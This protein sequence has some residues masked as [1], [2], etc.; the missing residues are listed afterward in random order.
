MLVGINVFCR[1]A[2]RRCLWGIRK[3]FA[4]LLCLA[5][6]A[7]LIANPC[8]FAAN[9]TPA[10][11]NIILGQPVMMDGS[12]CLKKYGAAFCACTPLTG[13]GE[14]CFYRRPP[15]G[16]YSLAQCEHSS[17]GEPRGSPLSHHRTSDVAYGGF[18]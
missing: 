18:S 6:I 7:A 4:R 1:W 12:T 11:Q 8:A 14:G 16:P 17:R 15:V 10:E 5:L 13:G 9:Y 2:I 3:A